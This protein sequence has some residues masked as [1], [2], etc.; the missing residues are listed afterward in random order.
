MKTPF[1]LIALSPLFGVLVLNCG[2][3]GLTQEQTNQ[4]RPVTNHRSLQPV[5]SPF[6]QRSRSVFQNG[7]LAEVTRISNRNPN[8][9]EALV[10]VL[11]EASDDERPELES[12]IQSELEKQYDE[13]LARNEDQIEKLQ[14]RIDKLKDQV[15][16]RRSAK[17]RMVDLEF[18]RV[19][20]EAEGLVWP[21][22]RSGPLRDAIKRGFRL[23]E[24]V[25]E[26][27]WPEKPRVPLTPRRSK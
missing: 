4:T 15:M 13:F 11:K 26:V 18:E 2:S 6:T 3:M 8:P 23:P 21:E 25:E 16:R 7:G 10:E 27:R 1:Y 5:L 17:A 22:D 12:K 9:I 24:N 19:I 14:E 20:N